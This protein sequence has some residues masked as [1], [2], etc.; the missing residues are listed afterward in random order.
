MYPVKY[1]MQWVLVYS[2]GCAHRSSLLL[3]IFITSGRTL[4]SLPTSLPSLRPQ[5]LAT[6]GLC[7]VQVGTSQIFPPHGVV[8]RVPFC[9][10][11]LAP[12]IL[13]PRSIC[14]VVSQCQRFLPL[15]GQG[16]VHRVA[17]LLSI[18]LPLVTPGLRS[19]LQHLLQASF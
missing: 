9:A 17:V 11:L 12:R 2:Q 4:H 18:Q 13:Y 19:Q 7:S 14:V 16:L 15:H 8:R 10:C 5:P 6:T 3:S 1:T